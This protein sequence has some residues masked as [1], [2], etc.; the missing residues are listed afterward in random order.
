MPKKTRTRRRTVP[1]TR[2]VTEDMFRQVYD[3]PRSLPG[4]YAWLTVEKDVREIERLLGMD[5]NTIGAPLWVSGDSKR[6]PKCHREINWL[7]IVASGLS[8]VHSKE[9]LVRVILGDRKYINTEAPRAIADLACFNCHTPIAD[10]RSF[11]CHNWAY[12]DV[13]MLKVIQQSLKST[14]N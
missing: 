3:S 13:D 8:S 2:V 10:L 1:S 6:C 11:K 5:A 9:T 4:K 12:A 14:T 7:D